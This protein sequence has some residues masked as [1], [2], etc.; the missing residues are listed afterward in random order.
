[1]YN[2]CISIF[3]LSLMHCLRSVLLDIRIINTIR[4][5]VFVPLSRD[6]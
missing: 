2:P 5:L 3:Y 1:M 4:S 6:R